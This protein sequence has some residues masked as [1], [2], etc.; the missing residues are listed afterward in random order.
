M[1]V[2]RGKEWWVVAGV[3]GLVV[4]VMGQGWLRVRMGC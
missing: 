3:K 1:L 4:V 2:V